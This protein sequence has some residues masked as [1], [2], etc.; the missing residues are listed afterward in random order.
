V[1]AE[2]KLKRPILLCISVLALIA[3]CGDEQFQAPPDCGGRFLVVYSRQP[4]A[5]QGDLYL[6]DYDGLGFHLLPGINAT[7]QAELNPTLSRNVRFIAFER[8][9]TPTDH[10]ILVYD[11]CQAASVSPPGLNNTGIDRD[12]AFSGDA[13]K[14]AFVR[15][16][17]G[18]REV[19]LYDGTIDRLVPL[20]GIE[21]GSSYLDSSPTTNQDATLIAFSRSAAGNDDVLIYDTVNDSLVDYPDLASSGSDVDP[22]MTP[23][24]RYVV[25]ASDRDHPGDYDLFLYDLQTRVFITLPAAANTPMTE[26]HPSVNFSTDRIAFESN[27]TGTQGSSDIYLLTR[28]TGSVANSGSSTTTDVQPWIAWQ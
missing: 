24:G 9:L 18:R 15:D 1:E 12:P 26:R 11:R 10:D 14:M 21:G 2:A 6:F 28:S 16:T 3:G 25:F 27:R 5:D 7:G 19:R 8:V 23:D 17:L 22:A 20:P 13:N 4:A